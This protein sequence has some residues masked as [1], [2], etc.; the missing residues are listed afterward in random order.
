M[1]PLHLPLDSP[2]RASRR[3]RAGELALLLVGT[4]ALGL[5]A[6]ACGKRGDPLPP[7]RIIPAPTKDLSVH[8]RG[9]ELDLELAYPT[10]TAAGTPLPP[11]AT[12]EVFVVEQPTQ[13]GRP[14][15]SLQPREFEALAK[16]LLTLRGPE[17][18]NAT[19]GDR[20]VLRLPLSGELPAIPPAAPTAGAAG[21]DASAATGAPAATTATTESAASAATGAA[22]GTGETPAATGAAADDA[23][24]AAAS[25]TPEP[26]EPATTAATPEAV[27]A[28]AGAA[29]APSDAPSTAPAVLVNAHVYAVRLTAEGG[30]PGAFSNLAV[31][32]PRRPP[33]PPGSLVATAEADAVALRWQEVPAVTGYLVYRRAADSKAWGKPLTKL[34][35]VRR[36]YRDTEARYG[37]RYVY[38]VSAVGAVDPVIESALSSE[39]EVVYEDRFAP[40][41]PTGLVALGEEQRVRLRWQASAASDVA[42][43]VVFRQDPGGEWRSITPQPVT[44]TEYRDT[45]LASGLTYAYRVLAVDQV[46]NQG[47]ASEPTSVEVR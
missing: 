1:T 10:T 8:Q 38:A 16:P 25:P 24:A 26:T 18:T 42:G 11:L 28:P 36:A 46:G 3:R 43:Y 13:E 7:I 27:P 37:Q 17:L 33:Q 32:V 9:M 15:P 45:G 20:L 23:P 6:S 22:A 47:E 44:T 31:I 30:E 34:D 29:A 2:L 21:A 5:A 12:V 39:Q 40:P 4:V 14:L 35:A 41:P 19:S